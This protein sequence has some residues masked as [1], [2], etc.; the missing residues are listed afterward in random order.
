MS[1]LKWFFCN[2]RSKPRDGNEFSQ[3]YLLRRDIDTCFGIDPDTGRQMHPI[4]KRSKKPLYCRAIWPGTMAI[5]AGIDLLGKFRAGSDKSGG[6]GIHGV[7]GRFEAFAQKCM[8]LSKSDARLIYQLRNSLLHSFGLYTE[9]RNKKGRIKSRYYFT[10][11][12]GARELIVTMKKDFYRIDVDRLRALFDSSINAYHRELTTPG[13]RGYKTR[14]AGF[15]KMLRK[16][17][18]GIFIYRIEKT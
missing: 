18:K 2:P 7:G 16:H 17:A 13:K 15:N 10:L 4:S 3:L 12:Q 14:I 1:R 5:L 6:K 8:H 11:C 9:I